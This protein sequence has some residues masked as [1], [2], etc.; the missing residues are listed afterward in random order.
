MGWSAAIGITTLTDSNVSFADQQ[1][2]I[3]KYNPAIKRYLLWGVVR[4]V[5]SLSL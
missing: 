3:H 1:S 5:K 2:V 4:A